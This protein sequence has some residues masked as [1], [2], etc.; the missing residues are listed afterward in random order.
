MCTMSKTKKTEQ[1]METWLRLDKK[2]L[3]ITDVLVNRHTH[4]NVWVQGGDG[5]FYQSNREN[6]TEFYSPDP[7]VIDQERV[8]LARVLIHQA[9]ERIKEAE[10]EKSSIRWGLVDHSVEVALVGG[11]KLKCDIEGWEVLHKA[12]KT[13]KVW[14]SN[15]AGAGW[16]R[17]EAIETTKLAQE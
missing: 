17:R 14:V 9:N 10:N 2:T 11:T 1:K 15:E 3:T 8:R 13:C 12:L 6:F 7:Q 16:S 4:V 5:R